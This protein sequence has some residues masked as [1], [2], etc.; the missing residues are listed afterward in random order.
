MCTK[1]FTDFSVS[2]DALNGCF[3]QISQVSEQSSQV[4][5]DG[6]QGY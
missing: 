3:E 6:I 4:M 1:H 5:G 2:T